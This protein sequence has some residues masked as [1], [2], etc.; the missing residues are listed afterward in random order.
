MVQPLNIRTI[1]SA[2]SGARQYVQD[3]KIQISRRTITRA[4]YGE[5]WPDEYNSWVTS[6]TKRNLY[7]DHERFFRVMYSKPELYARKFIFRPID[8]S[9]IKLIKSATIDAHRIIIQQLQKFIAAPNYSGSQNKSTGNYARR[10]KIM[11]SGRDLQSVSQLDGMSGNDTVTL[12]DTAEYAT[13]SESNALYHAGVGGIFYF[14]AK[15]IRKRYPQLSIRFTFVNYQARV[16]G[17]ARPAG[18]SFPALTIGTH[19]T[20]SPKLQKPRKETY[21]S[22]T[23]KRR[24]GYK[25]RP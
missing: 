6:E 8:D 13:R 21:N 5:R 18:S 20:V 24:W 15:T 17:Q 22:K 1:K 9:H 3:E 12:L 16:L 4:Q 10:I 19:S 7:K 11:L 23:G 25:F 14:A 2:V